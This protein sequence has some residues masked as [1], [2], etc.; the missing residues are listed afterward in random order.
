MEMP[1]LVGSLEQS[2][3]AQ[4]GEYSD[5]K[6]QGVKGNVLLKVSSKWQL[7]R[8]CHLRESK[9]EDDRTMARGSVSL[10]G[11][12]LY[13]HGIILRLFISFLQPRLPLAPFSLLQYRQT[14]GRPD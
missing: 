12:K 13:M 11:R 5:K 4:G 1:L 2:K 8:V 9:R 3:G 14:H 7:E 6:R 10:E